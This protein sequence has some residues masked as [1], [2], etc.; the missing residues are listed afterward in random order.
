M[1]S[2]P[3][4]QSFLDLAGVPLGG[5]DPYQSASRGLHDPLSHARLD[6]RP[7]LDRRGLGQDQGF[8]A[9]HPLSLSQGLVAGNLQLPG[10]GMSSHAAL[11]AFLQGGGAGSLVAQDATGGGEAML[12]PSSLLSTLNQLQKVRAA[13]EVE[14]IICSPCSHH[15]ILQPR[16]QLLQVLLSLS[17]PGYLVWYQL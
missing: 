9:A 1:A 2:N 3:G 17:T 12:F 5:R 4:P 16:F 11:A 8:Q 7:Q 15:Q 14:C 10:G 13:A 6:F